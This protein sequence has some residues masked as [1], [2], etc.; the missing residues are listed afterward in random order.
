[1]NFPNATT[2]SLAELQDKIGHT[3]GLSGWELID[4]PLIDRFAHITRDREFIHTDPER[5][6]REGPFGGT[7]A[8]GLLIL[9]LVSDMANRALPRC[10]QVAS[11]VNYGYDKVRFI[12]PVRCG[13]RVRAH[14]TLLAVEPR[15]E[16]QVLI[17]Y[18]VRVEVDNELK[19]ALIADWS[20]LLFLRQ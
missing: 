7:I 8:H 17:R 14:F 5:A 1:M 12:A 15:A 18:A 6:R 10:A 20:S 13:S 4:Q 3:L 2:L 11:G 9:S 19:P 16:R